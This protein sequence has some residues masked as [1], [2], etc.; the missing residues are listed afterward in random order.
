[1]GGEG[2]GWGKNQVG[3]RGMALASQNLCYS[4]FS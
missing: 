4:A 3:Y 2:G 1:V